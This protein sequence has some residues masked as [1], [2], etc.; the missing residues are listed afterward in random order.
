MKVN[1]KKLHNGA[2]IPT[3][4]SDE[5]A[6]YDLYAYIPRQNETICP[7]ET[8]VIGT[9]IALEI[10]KGYVGLVYARSGLATKRALRP[11]NCVGVIDSD[12]RGEI[13]IALHNDGKE[14]QT[15]QIHDRVAQIVVAPYL[16]VEFNEVNELNDTNRGDGGFGSAGVNKEPKYE[17]P[18][19]FDKARYDIPE[20]VVNGL[21]YSE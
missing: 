5:A 12:Y 21:R 18:S 7:G 3:R 15:I 10:P 20:G 19:L 6:G 2:V 1:I 8:K 13:G 14:A 4:G 16:S 9:G 11:A 17:Q